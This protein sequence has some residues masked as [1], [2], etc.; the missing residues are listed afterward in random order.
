MATINPNLSFNGNCEAAFDFYKSVFGGEFAF[1]GR[2]KDMP[3]DQPIPD[4]DKEKIMHIAYPIGKT[5]LMGADT[6]QSCGG[7]PVTFGDNVSLTISTETEDEA[8]RIFAALSV[9]GQ[10]VVPQEEAFWGALFGYLVDK[11]GI[12]WMVNY[13][14]NQ[15]TEK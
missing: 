11:F 14:Y 10:V 9:D 12:H 1:V 8:K 13:E 6:S 7:M 15:C 5:I 2:Y 4:S 3:S